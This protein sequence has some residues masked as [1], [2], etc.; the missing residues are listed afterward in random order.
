MR[1]EIYGC[2]TLGSKNMKIKVY[3]EE[4]VSRREKQFSTWLYMATMLGNNDI[5][6]M[7]VR[8]LRRVIKQEQLPPL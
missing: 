4:E 8:C 3:N 7:V 5:A 6:T 1:I 2:S